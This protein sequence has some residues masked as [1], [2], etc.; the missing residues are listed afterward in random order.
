MQPYLTYA[1]LLVRGV[2]ISISIRLSSHSTLRRKR[3]IS[4]LAASSS[5]AGGLA[6]SR[7]MP[8]LNS[9]RLAINAGRFWDSIFPS[10]TIQ[11]RFFVPASNKRM[12]TKLQDRSPAQ[13][14]P[15]KD[16]P[17]REAEK[18][19]PPS[20]E[21][22]LKEP[23]PSEPPAQGME[24]RAGKGIAECRDQIYIIWLLCNSFPASQMPPTVHITFR[25]DM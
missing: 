13:E 3:A 25:T 11:M 5:P 9:S 15:A 18:H 14:P 6:S 8:F 10:C 1:A 4:R 23:P 22:L 12:M 2:F 21:P 17:A 24:R 16:P 20:D 19:D 7:R